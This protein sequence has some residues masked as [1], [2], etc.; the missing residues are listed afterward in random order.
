MDPA[1][2]VLSPFSAEERELEAEACK[3]AAEAVK[4]IVTEGPVKAMNL[5]NQR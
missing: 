1:D 2:Y 5:F 3:K 4:A